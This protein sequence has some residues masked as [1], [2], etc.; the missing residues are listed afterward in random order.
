MFTVSRHC[1]NSALTCERKLRSK[2]MQHHFELPNATE[3]NHSG[4][5]CYFDIHYVISYF[6]LCNSIVFSAIVAKTR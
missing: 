5:V 4:I 2:C 1:C 6:L 3:E